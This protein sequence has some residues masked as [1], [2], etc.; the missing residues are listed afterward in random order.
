M[1][2]A[3]KRTVRIQAGGRIEVVAP[4]LPEGGEA[5]VIV[6]V[7]EA[8]S[9]TDLWGLFADCPE[10]MDEIVE[11]AMAERARPLRLPGEESGS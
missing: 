4:E 3:L 7:P 8:R 2:R 11:E 1:V 5:E 10:L 6:L 9:E